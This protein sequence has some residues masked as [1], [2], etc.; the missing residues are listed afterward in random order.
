VLE[1]GYTV[2]MWLE[3]T[4]PGAE[5]VMEVSASSVDAAVEKVMVEQNVSYAFYVWV[6]PADEA[7]VCE[8]RFGVQLSPSAQVGKA[9]G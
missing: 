8:E 3:E 4:S 5:V 2:Y 6:V 1:V 7:S 9:Q